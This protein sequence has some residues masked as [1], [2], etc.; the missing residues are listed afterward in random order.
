M[1]HT[2]IKSTNNNILMFPIKLF[3]TTLVL[4]NTAKYLRYTDSLRHKTIMLTPQQSH[5][6]KTTVTWN[7][8]LLSSFKM[9]LM[10]SVNHEN[11]CQ[12]WIFTLHGAASRTWVSILWDILYVTLFLRTCNIRWEPTGSNSQPTHF[13]MHHNI[14][15]TS[16]D[17]SSMPSSHFWFI[18]IPTTWVSFLINP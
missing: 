5:N 8:L 3:S 9:Y 11:V 7:T 13:Y 6:F 15:E 16:G 14:K 2:L 17:V 10:M 1:A 12:Q 4:L 18:Q